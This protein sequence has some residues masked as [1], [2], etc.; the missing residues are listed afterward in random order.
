[1]NNNAWQ[2]QNFITSIDE[3]NPFVFVGTVI[4]HTP[5]PLASFAKQDAW[6]AAF[7]GT[8]IALIFVWFYIRV[9]NL[10]PDLALDQINDKVSVSFSTV[11]SSGEFNKNSLSRLN[12]KTSLKST[13]VAN[14]DY[15]DVSGGFKKE[16]H[17][18]T[19]RFNSPGCIWLN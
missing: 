7:L 8:G 9:E 15:T 18:N 11:P 13:M 19:P 14:N 12:L 17:K 1:M 10:Y 3:F 5:S 6:L 2:F 4:L 16:H